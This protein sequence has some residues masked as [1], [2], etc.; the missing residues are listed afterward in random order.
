MK[1]LAPLTPAFIDDTLQGSVKEFYTN[2]RVFDEIASAQARFLPMLRDTFT[3]NTLGGRDTRRLT[4]RLESRRLGRTIASRDPR[5]F[6]NRVKPRDISYEALIAIDRSGSTYA[7]RAST[8]G[9]VSRVDMDM[10]LLAFAQAFML[11]AAGIPVTMLWYNG[12]IHAPAKV[13]PAEIALS[14]SALHDWLFAK[15]NRWHHN[16]RGNGSQSD[17]EQ[18]DVWLNAWAR[19][20]RATDRV[21]FHYTDGG[22]S[23]SATMARVL[24]D[25]YRE[26]HVGA[27]LDTDTRTHLYAISWDSIAPVEMG[28]DTILVGESAKV[29]HGDDANHLAL[30][31]ERVVRGCAERIT[32]DGQHQLP[33][34]TCW[35]NLAQ[36]DGRV[37]H[38]VSE[39]AYSNPVRARGDDVIHVPSI[40]TR[41]DFEL[42]AVK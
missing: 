26:Q 42:G 5:A 1:I 22:M 15:P 3:S 40:P 30:S 13:L 2:T 31:V 20:S 34:R 6:Y 24:A 4:G 8:R 38:D 18:L 11:E 25:H 7:H 32:G 23:V 29:G 17:P 36:Y 21:V 27:T 35:D 28:L 12:N 39:I 33:T 19:S 9:M 37:D 41:P 14:P 16:A 10:T